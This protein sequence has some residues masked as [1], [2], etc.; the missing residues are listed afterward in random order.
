MIKTAIRNLY[1]IFF[2]D[3]FEEFKQLHHQSAPLL[4]G[5]VW[6]AMSAKIFEQL[7]FKAVATSSAALARTMGY[8]DGEKIPFDLLLKMVERI[9]SNINI[10]LSV[11]MEGGYSRN[12]SPIIQNIQRLHELGVVGINIEDSVKGEKPYMQPA[13]DFKKILSSIAEHLQKKNMKLFINARTDAYV[14]K[15]SS[16]LDETLKRIQLYEAAGAS[17]IFVPY[18]TDKN[19]IKKVVDSTTLPLNVF[20]THNLPNFKELAELGVRRISMATVVYRSALKATEKIIQTILE[21]Q[22][23][24]SLY[25][26]YDLPR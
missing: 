9:I 25:S 21:E 14:L 7:G 10:P 11:D 15:L 4:I 17:G 8:E 18:L 2:M 20:A 5:N 13:E 16:P 1:K 24:A 22:S 23:F 19:E 12:I 6:D 3:R 26:T